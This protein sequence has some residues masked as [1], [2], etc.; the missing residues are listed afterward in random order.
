MH[1]GLSSTS[2]WQHL[3]LLDGPRSKLARTSLIE[4]TACCGLI[5]ACGRAWRWQ[6]ALELLR[7]AG[8]DGPEALADMRDKH[9]TPSAA[10]CGAAI[11]PCDRA[12]RWTTALH[13]MSEMQYP[14]TR[15]TL[16]AVL[17]TLTGSEQWRHAV[18]LVVLAQHLQGADSV[19]VSSLINTCSELAQWLHVLHYVASLWRH[20]RTSSQVG[21]T[22]ID[23][24]MLACHF[25]AESH[26]EASVYRHFR[27]LLNSFGDVEQEVNS[28][29]V[30]LAISAATSSGAP[31]WALG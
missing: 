4:P 6:T 14:L 11:S 9:L 21:R 3:M 12:R 16:G 31:C 10:T 20:Q 7:H 15:F 29:L 30:P 23:R 25:S 1:L 19:M 8:S 2:Q 18:R 13:L 27:T 5:S 26:A 24:N 28:L 17:S 22:Q